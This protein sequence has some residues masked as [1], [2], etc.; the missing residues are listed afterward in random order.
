M[1]FIFG[2]VWSIINVGAGYRF[3]CLIAEND[4]RRTRG[5]KIAWLIFCVF[6]GL[7]IFLFLAIM[8]FAGGW[9]VKAVVKKVHA[10]MIPCD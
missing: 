5:E 1:M 6:I 9:I 2:F 3:V 4:R 10:I 8:P 7:P